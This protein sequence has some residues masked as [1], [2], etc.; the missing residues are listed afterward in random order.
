MMRSVEEQFLSMPSL[1]SK[2]SPFSN[3]IPLNAILHLQRHPSLPACNPDH[4]LLKHMCLTPQRRCLPSLSTLASHSTFC[5]CSA[6]TQRAA[7]IV[8]DTIA[9]RRQIKLNAAVRLQ[10]KLN[11]A[12]CLS[13]TSCKVTPGAP[14]S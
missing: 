6:P 2:S 13:V 7:C 5:C 10:I 14:I 12:V 9:V 4:L 1:S 8:G 3:V 11:A